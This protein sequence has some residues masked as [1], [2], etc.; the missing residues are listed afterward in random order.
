[1]LIKEGYTVI[2]IEIDDGGYEVEL[3]DKNGSAY[4]GACLCI[5]GN[6]APPW[7]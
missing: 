4:R 2:D 1:M 6:G 7:S 3:I 5:S